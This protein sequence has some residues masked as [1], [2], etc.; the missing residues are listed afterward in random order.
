MTM[1]DDALTAGREAY[2]RRAWG[3]AY[4]RLAGA[5]ALGAEDLDRLAVAAYLIGRLDA[6]A[7]AW[8]QAYRAWLRNNQPA[9]A[10]RCGARSGSA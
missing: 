2:E 5:G 7:A 8:E 9:R 1:T 6:C 10:A 4:H 3:D